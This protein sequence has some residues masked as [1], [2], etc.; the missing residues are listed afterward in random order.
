MTLSHYEILE[1]KD[2]GFAF[3]LLGINQEDE[4]KQCGY[5]IKITHQESQILKTLKQLLDT[6]LHYWQERSSLLITPKYTKVL[7]K[8]KFFDKF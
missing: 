1:I 8:C 6:I 5:W 4:Q 2:L 3:G 7:R